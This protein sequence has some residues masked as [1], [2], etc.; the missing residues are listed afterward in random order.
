MLISVFRKLRA[1]KRISLSEKKI[2]LLIC[3]LNIKLVVLAQENAP[4]IEFQ[5]CFGWTE[6]KGDEG[7]KTIFSNDGNLI[8]LAKKALFDR[9][10][11]WISKTN[12]KGDII[13]ETCIYN[14]NF[15]GNYKPTDIIQN[16][17]GELYVVGTSMEIRDLVYSNY[18]GNIRKNMVSK[19]Y[20]DIFITKLN[21]AGFPIW[22]KNMGGSSIDIPK[23]VLIDDSQKIIV[24]GYSYSI[25]AD[26]VNT[27]KNTS[28]YNS[29]FFVMSFDTSGALLQKKCFGGRGDEILN[30]AI[31]NG[32]GDYILVGKST[33]NDEIV[34]PNRGDIDCYYAKIT[35]NLELISQKTFGG[36]KFDEIKS[37]VKR[38]NGN[39]VF[40]LNS[41]SF[42]GDFQ[43]IESQVIS[44]N[45]KTNIWVWE[46]DNNLNFYRRKIV[47][48][49]DTDRLNYLIETVDN[50]L[51]MV[52]T[53]LSND[54]DIT[55]RM[56]NPGN[57][58]FFGDV[59]LMK[60]NG[61]LNVAWQRTI[62]GTNHDEGFDVLEIGQD[63]FYISATTQSSNADVVGNHV[64]NVDDKDFWFVNLFVPCQQTL[65]LNQVL[66]NSQENFPA[67]NLINSVDKIQNNSKVSY[68]AGKQ[69]NLLPGFKID[70]G[71]VLDVSIANCKDTTTAVSNLPIQ[72][73]F[74][75]ECREGG[76]KFVFDT[77]SPDT[78]TNTYRLGIENLNPEIPFS[79]SGNSLVTYNNSP[80]NEKNAYYLLTV[81]KDNH[82]DFYH[83]G[84]TSS[85]EHDGAPLECPENTHD[86]ILN[87]KYYAVGDTITATWTGGLLAGQGLSWFN[88]N[89]TTITATNNFFRGVIT[90][91]P[92]KIQAQPSYPTLPR[93]CHG[94]V[95]VLLRK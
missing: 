87:K 71:A 17:L 57:I 68:R 93:P 91:F 13:W 83:Q 22:Q 26:L 14:E 12:L 76:M 54:G 15:T 78:L 23:K 42:D 24:F 38:A 77:I 79:F 44:D 16:S 32:S 41:S 65:N 35:S 52:G 33:S 43:A 28:T 4:I 6:T 90:N 81:S 18:S 49:N 1:I 47:G 86:L 62:G 85:C 21:S 67:R 2:I 7:V 66:T 19:G 40:G 74:R 64:N 88:E 58:N 5:K 75:Y 3:L 45:G 94:G 89:V 10:T 31:K 70:G 69:I 63:N 60:L 59:L 73:K 92:V 48:G 30:D 55:D 50:S 37:V 61:S 46:L 82:K 84:Y 95:T 29:D 20:F 51:V 25:D 11:Y 8:L 53:T 34:S 9:E 56:R 72:L 27:N 39:I 80:L 36:S